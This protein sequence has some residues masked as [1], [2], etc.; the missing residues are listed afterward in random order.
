LSLA[1]YFEP[2]ESSF[3]LQFVFFSV[4]LMIVNV[5]LD[6]SRSINCLLCT[7]C[8]LLLAGNIAHDREPFWREGRRL[9][10]DLCRAPRGPDRWVNLEKIQ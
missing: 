7:L 8:F 3:S 5:P 2:N 10:T 6:L 1:I 9:A 4:S